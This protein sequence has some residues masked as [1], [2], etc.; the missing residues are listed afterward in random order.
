MDAE[1]SIEWLECV[2][3]MRVYSAEDNILNS[4]LYGNLK[5]KNLAFYLLSPN[6]GYY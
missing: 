4:N 6:S 1:Y 2:W 3:A 5:A